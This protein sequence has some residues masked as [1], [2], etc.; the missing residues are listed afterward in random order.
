L[1]GEVFVGAVLLHDV[2]E[3]IVGKLTV[4]VPRHTTKKSAVADVDLVMD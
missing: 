1:I 2:P 3:K 4:Y